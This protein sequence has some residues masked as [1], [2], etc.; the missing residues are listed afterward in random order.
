MRNE[1]EK[2]DHSRFQHARLAGIRLDIDPTFNP[3]IVGSITDMSAVADNSMDALYSSHNI[4]HLYPHEVQIALKEFL[5]VLRPDGF[6]IVACPDLQ[7]VAELVAQDKLT[8]PA[9]QS[10]PDR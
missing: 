7:S 5:R 9:Y 8:E 10:P 2:P 1:A 3:D 4:E 6:A